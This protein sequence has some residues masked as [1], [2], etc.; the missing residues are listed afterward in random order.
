MAAIDCKTSHIG[1]CVTD[2][3]RA[4][5]FYVDGLGFEPFA[6]FELERDIAEVDPPVKLT[7]LFI[8]K[9]GNAGRQWH[10]VRGIK[11]ARDCCAA[12]LHAS[13]HQS[14]AAPGTQSTSKRFRGASPRPE[15]P[16]PTGGSVDRFP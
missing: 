14:P 9:N 5:R 6:R 3:D 12:T 15:S 13:L 8:Q 1:L 4:L 10:A 7:S 16:A 2:L 11:L